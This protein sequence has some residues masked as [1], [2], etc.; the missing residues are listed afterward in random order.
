MKTSDS[1]TAGGERSVRIAMNE[2]WI[3][4]S[5]EHLNKIE[6][7]IYALLTFP[8][9]GGIYLGDTRIHSFR[10]FHLDQSMVLYRRNDKHNFDI[11]QDNFRLVI[12]TGWSECFL[13]AQIIHFQIDILPVEKK[14]IFQ[15]ILPTPSKSSVAVSFGQN[16]QMFGIFHL[17]LKPVF[18]VLLLDNVE[19]LQIDSKFL[20]QN[21]IL[22]Y[23]LEWNASMDEFALE[24][25]QPPTIVVFRVITK[26][27]IR[28]KTLYVTYGKEFVLDARL[29]DY[30]TL[31]ASTERLKTE[32]VLKTSSSLKKALHFEFPQ[33]T[34][35]GEFFKSPP[36]N[37]EAVLLRFT[38]KELLEGGVRFQA[39]SNVSI[40]TT[41]ED[42]RVNVLAP[43]FMAP[44]Q[45]PIKITIIS[46]QYNIQNNILLSDFVDESS[47]I[48]LQNESPSNPP[49]FRESE[50][51]KIW[52]ATAIGIVCGIVCIL[53]IIA[54]FLLRRWRSKQRTGTQFFPNQIMHMDPVLP[55]SARG[56]QWAGQ[57][58]DQ[59]PSPSSASKSQKALSQAKSSLF[60]TDQD[61]TLRW[62]AP[63]PPLC[64]FHA[65]TVTLVGDECRQSN[66]CIFS[67]PQ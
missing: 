39:F 46:G 22:Y 15:D 26:P 4:L 21:R 10:A 1:A 54:Y 65:R 45:V 16:R 48:H 29:L 60:T 53:V 57:D 41:L 40:Q 19:I 11:L 36:S 18:G 7:A 20:P 59:L 12:C 37:D 38:Y 17:I 32:G 13:N 66:P 52:F 58:D 63:S 2:A 44:Q 55:K 64:L 9:Y 25:V 49:I 35:V 24:Q 5:S 30:S 28:F 43:M 51:L 23:R 27:L 56:L 3:P 31:Q 33:D 8:I 50:S 14:T 34:P 61:A 42:I 67:K 62:S 6:G 47:P